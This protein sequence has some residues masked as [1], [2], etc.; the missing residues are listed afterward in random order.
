MFCNP[1]FMEIDCEI[2]WF[3]EG[4][5]KTCNLCDDDGYGDDE[6]F[7]MPSFGSFY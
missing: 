1:T 2:D 3:K 7:D 4:C 5:A 6:T